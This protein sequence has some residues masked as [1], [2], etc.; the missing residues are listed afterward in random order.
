MV[1]EG[2]LKRENERER[3]LKGGNWKGGNGPEK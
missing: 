2:K 3:F 1:N